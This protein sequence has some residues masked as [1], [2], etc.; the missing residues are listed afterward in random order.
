VQRGGEDQE[1]RDEGEPL[2]LGCCGRG[3]IE[4]LGRRDRAVEDVED[5]GGLPLDRRATPLFLGDGDA[6]GVQ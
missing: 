1:R 5:E 2:A 4:Q 6:V 3:E